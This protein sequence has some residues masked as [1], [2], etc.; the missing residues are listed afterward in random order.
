M[1]VKIMTIFGTRPEAI[2]MAPIIKEL[3]SRKAH[4]QEAC[5]TGQHRQMLDQMLRLFNIKTAYDLEIMTPHQSLEQIS[6]KAL[7]GLEEVLEKNRPD[8]VLVQGDTTTALIG[9]LAAFYKK[10]PVG[11]VEA[12]LRTDSL[13]NPF[14]EEMNRRL[15]GQLAQLHFA[16]T[17]KAR[18][19]LLREG[20]KSD[21]VHVTGNTVIDAIKWVTTQDLPFQNHKLAN[22]DTTGKRVVL[23]TT[24]RRE[25]V[26]RGM[27]S[28]FETINR[29]SSEYSDLI[30]IYPVHL[31][32]AIQKLAKEAFGKN[33]SIVML[34]PL[35][36]PD[37][38]KVIQ[39]SYLVMTD[40]GGIQEEAPAF[41]KP[42]LVLRDTTERQEG[43]D[44][45]TA[46]LVGTD[47]DKIY[48]EA[49]KLLTDDGA[50]KEMAN[51]VNPYG[52]GTAAKKI[53]D[54][55]EQKIVIKN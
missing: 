22:L 25:N 9:A 45:G 12:G 46:K 47:N 29:L 32:P 44:A 15:I 7:L 55:I 39:K 24:H 5:V 1:P 26:G 38:A 27:K 43:V 3:E 19:N 40:S 49:K 17:E 21:L 14:P 30:F 37:L 2:K 54:I 10:I 34:E 28:I 36:Y 16:P 33:E 23:V 50:Y 41:G 6:S 4:A 11:H 8:M 20:I 48:S 53:V 42:V 52:D 35:E 51:A 13:Y 31:N 18:D